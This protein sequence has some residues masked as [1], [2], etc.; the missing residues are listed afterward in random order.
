M[1]TYAHTC[2]SCQLTFDIV[3]RIADRNAAAECPGCGDPGAMRTLVN[4]VGLFKPVGRRREAEAM[5]RDAAKP[6]QST[7]NSRNTMVN[8]SAV[9]CHTGITVEN[10]SL[11]IDGFTAVNCKRAIVSKN[12]DVRATKI[13][14]R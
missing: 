5:S 8:C 10:G 1:P 2:P 6:A 14:I 3:R 4:L 11:E 9:D 13:K 7:W 12:A